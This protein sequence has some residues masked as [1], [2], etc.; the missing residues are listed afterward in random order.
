VLLYCSVD[1]GTLQGSIR[2]PFE[3]ILMLIVWG[4]TGYLSLTEPAPVIGE[5][6]KLHWGPQNTV[7]RTVANQSVERQ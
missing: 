6:A 1:L 3:T 4:W 2:I 7:L 5:I